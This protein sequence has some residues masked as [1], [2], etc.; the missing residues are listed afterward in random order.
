MVE[1]GGN[2][3]YSIQGVGSTSFQWSSGDTLK[4]EDILYV[5]RLKKNLIFVS[6]LE[7]KGFYVIFLENQAY[8]WP[9]NQN[10]DNTN[11]IGV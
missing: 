1:L 11:V 2:S 3:T 7:Y 4:V 9:K 6:V 8:L 5:P 10:I